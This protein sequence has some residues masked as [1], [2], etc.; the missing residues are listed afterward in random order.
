M[1]SKFKD[2]N[3]KKQQS[4]LLY[5]V[6]MTRMKTLAQSFSNS[7]WRHK[8]LSSISKLTGYR[9]TKQIQ[10]KIDGLRTGYGRA[11]L[12]VAHLLKIDEKWQSPTLF[13]VR[14]L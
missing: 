7:M 13:Q 8:Q 14:M 12:K 5:L 1:R 9:A 3:T 11:T 6:R 4:L 2:E 10:A